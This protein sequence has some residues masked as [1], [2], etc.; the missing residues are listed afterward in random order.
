MIAAVLGPTAAAT[1]A[2]SRQKVAGSMSANT[3]S[4]PASRTE[5]AVAA[6]VNDGTI[7]SSPAPIAAIV[8]AAHGLKV[9]EDCAQAHGATVHGQR[10]GTF[11]DAAAFSFYPTKNMTTGEG[12]MV[13]TSDHA[14][15]RQVRMLRNQ[16]M[17]RQYEN[18]V[19]GY[20]LRM[21]DIAAA[22]GLVQLR[23]LP[24]FTRQRQA[25]ALVLDAALADH[26]EVQRPAVRPGAVHVYHQYTVRS[27]DRDRLQL[28]LD[29]AG[30]ESRVY[31]PI[32][33]HR[34]APYAAL[35]ADLPETDRAAADVLSVPVGP[36]LND[37]EVATVADAL[38]A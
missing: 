26:A 22:I 8:E 15:A 27:A 4:A 6:K 36:H 23:R 24:G 34:L 11:G 17:E 9:L 7:T 21:T 12:G 18:E 3:G 28:R 32:P 5:L 19:V 33:V 16:G 10:V 13:V 29:G 2:G 37:D 31:Y 35:K 14:A 38:R 1:A 30:V 25:N 20:N